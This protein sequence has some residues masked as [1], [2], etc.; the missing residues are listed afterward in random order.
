MT[1]RERINAEGFR[2]EHDRVLADAHDG[3]V[4]YLE[5]D[6]ACSF[7]AHNGSSGEP[8]RSGEGSLAAFAWVGDHPL[9]R[10]E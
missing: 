5:A 7:P 3:A 1:A 6:A 8:G 4:G 9:N 10:P 2:P